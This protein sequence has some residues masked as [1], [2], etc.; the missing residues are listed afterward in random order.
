[1]RTGIS[2]LLEL[3]FVATL[4]HNN[5]DYRAT[6]VAELRSK[7]V[8]LYLAFLNKFDCGLLVDVGCCA[9]LLLRSASQRPVNT[10]FTIPVLN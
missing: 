7:A 4:F 5:V 8:V 10:D 2:L 6:V 9:F 1:M 3:Q